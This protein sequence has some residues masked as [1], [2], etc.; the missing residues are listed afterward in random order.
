MS[1]ARHRADGPASGPSLSRRAVITTPLAGISL[2]AIAVA[3]SRLGLNPDPE[4]VVMRLEAP[5]TKALPV[6]WNDALTPEPV[7]PGTPTPSPTRTPQLVRR[8]LKPKATKKPQAVSTSRRPVRSFSGKRDRIL[9]E[10][11]ALFGIYYLWGGVSPSTG[12]DCSGY[13]R[14]VYN[15]VGLYLPRVSRDQAAYMVP[16]RNPKPGDLVFFGNP[17]HHVGIYVKPG[18]MYDSPK[19]GEKSGTSPIWRSERTFY[20]RHPKL[21]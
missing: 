9:A 3:A 14:Y 16:V 6:D 11:E 5:E 15:K 1:R 4:T 7:A 8:E 2:A 12:F 13:T 20:A 19:K 21:M 17:V 10:A 18:L